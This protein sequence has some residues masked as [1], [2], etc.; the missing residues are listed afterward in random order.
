VTWSIAGLSPEGRARIRTAAARY[1]RAALTLN[2]VRA[3][4][5]GGFADLHLR[6]TG[7]WVSCTRRRSRTPISAS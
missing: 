4:V 5:E 6:S 2:F 3:L 1:E 7:I